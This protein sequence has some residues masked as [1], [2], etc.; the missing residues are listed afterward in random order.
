MPDHR[1]LQAR[2]EE[3]D[4]AAWPRL[5]DH[6][7]ASRIGPVL[8]GLQI[9]DKVASLISVAASASPYLERLIT[10]NIS[11]VAPLLREDANRSLEQLLDEA[12][13]V[14]DDTETVKAQLRQIKDRAMILFSLCDLAGVSDD[15][16][17]MEA[18]SSFADVAVVKAFASALKNVTGVRSDDPLQDCG[19]VVLGMGK[20]GAGELNYSSDI[21]LV[22]FYDPY[23]LQAF[24]ETNSAQP[25]LAD[26]RKVA[27]RATQT[28][29]S[30]LQDL[31]EDGYVFRTDLRLRPDPGTSN[32]AVTVGAA[33]LYYETYGQN[34][35]R[36]AFSKARV[37]AGHR[38]VSK[39][40]TDFLR[41]FIWRKYLDYAAIEDIH[42]IK[43]QI[44]AVKGMGTISFPGHDIKLGRGGIREIEFFV[45]TQQLI[46]G[47][48]NRALRERTTLGGLQALASAGHIKQNVA[49]ELR[50]AYLLLRRV[51]HRIQMVN[52]EQTHTIPRQPDQILRLAH[53]AGYDDSAAFEQSVTACLRLVHDH[54]A[55]LFEEG[56]RLSARRGSLVFTGVDDHPDTLT[57]LTKMGYRDASHI[58]ATIRNWHAGGIRA[59]KSTRAR[60]L[61]TKLVPMILRTLGRTDDPQQSFNSFD[62]LLRHMPGGV[63]FFSLVLNNPQVL[64]DLVALSCLSPSLAH[65][66][67]THA[68][69]VEA[70]LQTSFLK[71]ERR[72]MQSALNRLEGEI[73]EQPSFE[74]A[75]NLLRRHVRE[76]RFR[77]TSRLLLTA[78]GTRQQSR[79]YTRQAEIA[80]R[81]SLPVARTEMIRN[82]GEI[83][84]A[85][86]I[87][88]MGRLGAS[89]LTATSDLDLIFVYDRQETSQSD[90]EQPLDGVTWFTRYVR[91]LLTTLSAQTE[92][93]GLYEVDMALRPSGSAGPAA[94]S[95]AAFQRYYKEEAWTWEQ[96]AL[97][98]A[99]VV[100]GAPGLAAMISDEITSILTRK[101]DRDKVTADALNMRQRLLCDKPA[102]SDW[103]LKLVNGGLTDIDFI[104][105]HLSLLHAHDLGRFPPHI[106]DALPVF[107]SQELIPPADAK[108]LLA[109][110][111]S[112]ETTMQLIRAAIG[113][114]DGADSIPPP[115][116]RALAARL[117]LARPG[118]ILPHLAKHR[119]QV[120]KIFARQIGTL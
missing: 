22:V 41:P 15:L 87:I 40:V 23:I 16:T 11:R 67:A 10:R 69:L 56:E 89:A 5:H 44:H 26:P 27:I 91:R 51:E 94:V 39:Q 2:I 93:G 83:E 86:A 6:A 85:L 71:E 42:S 8:T 95:L 75:L 68:H 72:S 64:D 111:R 97:V 4:A 24:L 77:V 14:P 90:H 101:R 50:V 36:A 119:E 116:A 79:F 7:A 37:I 92:E 114:L 76:E 47:G 33:E 9:S 20:H 80:I 57:T 103:D 46:L 88:G 98:K 74:E 45:Q 13:N 30:I 32:I 82:H 55:D 70:M 73:A 102:A 61:L 25:R 18:L 60:E 104:C 58:S 113:N 117:D 53:L 31:T 3:A 38:Q 12:S 29:V 21:D 65:E 34:W 66:M 118:D 100:A 109:A 108:K 63:Q 1:P 54:Y 59:T 19:F 35:E 115:L 48:R 120:Q 84:G 99:R 110:W 49:Q 17:I 107:A 62:A 28:A 105:Q 43:R 52:D 112:Y 78:A 81:A 96:M 106:A